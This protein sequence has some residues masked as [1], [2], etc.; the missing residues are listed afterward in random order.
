[1]R[2]ADIRHVQVIAE[3]GSFS[4]AAQLLHISQP[5][6]SQNIQRLER[7]IGCALFDRN[8]K[9]VTLTEEGAYFLREGEKIL[10]I[11]DNLLQK[12]GGARAAVSGILNVAASSSYSKYF[13]PKAFSEFSSRHP[14]IRLRLLESSSEDRVQMM[15][16]NEIDFMIIREDYARHF[17]YNRLFQERYYFVLPDSYAGRYPDAFYEKNGE[18][19]VRLE[20]FA[21]EFF[22][23]YTNGS[24][25]SNLVTDLC[26]AHGFLPDVTFRTDDPEIICALVS[27][28]MG[29]SVVSNV[30]RIHTHNNH[31]VRFYSVDDPLMAQ[32]YVLAWN[33]QSK[34][35]PAEED[36]L[37]ILQDV[38]QS[39]NYSLLAE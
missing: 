16:N 4:R 31:A 37:Q 3:C 30:T 6:L 33:G 7:E 18:P 23:S 19:Y 10:V 15:Q 28:G 32:N 26:I 9:S 27:T 14:E 13:F 24:V 35:T 20:A 5:A 17:V 21:G 8:R 25:M 12:L 1:M 11:T 22:L 34:L 29:V 2:I 39:M 36:F 38:H